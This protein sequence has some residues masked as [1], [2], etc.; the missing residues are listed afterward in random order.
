M[1]TQAYY[2]WIRA[3][4][5]SQVARPIKAI[6]DR[7][8]AH[9]YTVY[10]LGNGA[11]QTANTP[12]DH[13][14]FSATGWPGR[15]PYPYVNAADIMPLAAGQRSKLDGKPLPSLQQLARALRADKMAED[16]RTGWLKYINWE[17][18]G[19]YTGPCWHDSWQPT[20]ARQAS[21]DRGHIHVSGRSDFVTS[22]V[23]DGYDLV[24]RARGEDDDVTPED[25][26]SITAAVVEQL[27]PALLRH[28]LTSYNSNWTVGAS[29]AYPQQQNAEALARLAEALARLDAIGKRVDI[30][31]AEIEAIKTALP[32]AQQNAEATV[33]AMGALSTGALVDLLRRGLGDQRAREL[34]AALSGSA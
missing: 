22:A 9:G 33:E 13:V 24:A 8:R 27:P 28:R 2:D 26:K 14:P 19:D 15:H 30:D 4:Q 3:G 17:P 11:H 1:A 32:T 16:P 20:Y 21:T 31:P 5:P 34:G 7:L 18:D 10:Y 29:I 6:G 23:A 12:E 25:I